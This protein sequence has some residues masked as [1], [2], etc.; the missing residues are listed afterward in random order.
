MDNEDLLVSA[1]L[2]G[3]G[4]DSSSLVADLAARFERALPTHVKVEWSGWGKRRKVK[5]LTI[6][7]D[8]ERF[9]MQVHNGSLS[10]WIDQV[11]RGVCLRSDEVDM[12]GWLDRLAATLS[13][14]AKKSVET[15]LAI[16]DAL[17]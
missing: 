11:V 2:L 9:R 4:Q 16:E 14:E 15:R 10:A 8:Q 7:M 17:G 5:S 12:D 3:R 1:A 6:T 13:R